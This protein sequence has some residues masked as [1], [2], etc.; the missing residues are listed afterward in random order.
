MDLIFGLEQHI[1]VDG[2]G[3]GLEK[4]WTVTYGVTDILFGLI[5]FQM[6]VQSVTV[7]QVQTKI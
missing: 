7:L 6:T 5:E 1:M 4:S 2:S 3:Q